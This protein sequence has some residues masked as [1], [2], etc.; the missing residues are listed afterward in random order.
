MS[1]RHRFA[2]GV[3]RGAWKATRVSVRLAL[4]PLV[5]VE[6][7]FV[8]LLIY[9]SMLAQAR[10]RRNAP[11]EQTEGVRFTTERRRREHGETPR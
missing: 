10:H 9:W 3:T 5:A 7:G 11:K 1:R 4:L 2:A 6:W 8:L